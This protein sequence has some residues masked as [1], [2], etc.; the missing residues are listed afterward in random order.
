MEHQTFISSKFGSDYK[1]EQFNDY[2]FIYEMPEVK[3]KEIK[4]YDMGS[5]LA[6]LQVFYS[7]ADQIATPGLH[8]TVNVLDIEDSKDWKDYRGN[9]IKE[10]SLTLDDDEYINEVEIRSGAI[11]DKLTVRTN[12]KRE[13]SAGGNGGGFS[14]ITINKGEQLLAFTGSH[15]TS[16][17]QENSW[18][19]IHHLFV[20]VGKAPKSILDSIKK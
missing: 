10:H 4:L 20:H 8:C 19:T 15:A 16:E 11:I 6:G 12:K 2:D 17:N 14:Y 1:K 3:I 7:V 13:L 9:I 18:P 5:Y